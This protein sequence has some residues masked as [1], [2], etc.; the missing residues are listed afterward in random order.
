MSPGVLT[1]LARRLRL[2]ATDGGPAASRS[3]HARKRRDARAAV[4]C[5]AL[6]ALALNAGAVVVLDEL[7]PGV[8]DPE[9]ARRVARYRARVAENPGRPVV[10]VIGSSRAAMGVCPAAWEEVRRDGSAP[11]LFNMS[12]LGG[13]P[14]MEL[15]VARRAFADGLRPAVVLFEYWP[16]YL[17]SEGNWTETKRVAVERLSPVDRPVVRDYFPDRARVEAGMRR[18]RWNPLWESRERLL[19]QVFPR[20]LR[21]DRRIDWAWDNVDA[22]GWKAGFDYPPGPTPERAK[23][24]AACRD[25]Y[26]PLFANYRISPS[27]DRA[28]R[29]AVAVAREHGAAVGFVY[30]PESS[31]FRGWYPPRVEQLAREHLARLGREL[32]VPV[33]DART[34]MDDGLLV[35][36]FHL[37][38]VGAAEFTRKLGPAVAA[39]FPEA[40]P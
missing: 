15:M 14:V 1:R 3:P 40:R 28:L 26:R 18:H 11:V 30:L 36:G 23:L 20:W 37:S 7:R 24:L 4:A 29:E 35:D 10:L 32:A 27:A 12:L 16:P 33:I 5:F 39:T 17:Y 19:V 21:N 6:A 9:Y 13:G 2:R 38:R 22:W 34:W 31:E 25:I 8:R